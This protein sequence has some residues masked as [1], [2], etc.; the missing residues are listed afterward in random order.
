MKQIE[1]EISACCEVLA[2]GGTILY[3]TDTIWGIGCDATNYN[4]VNK[5][6]ILKQ[7]VESKSLIILL[8]DEKHLSRYV[9]RVPDITHD[10]LSQAGS[11]LTIIYPGA[12]NLAS[13][14]IAGDGTI[15]IRIAGTEFTR[16]LIAAFGKP[17]VSTSAN[18]SGAPSP[19]LFR[20]IDPEIRSG[21]DH[22]TDES[23][24]RLTTTKPSR[25]IRLNL[26]GDFE[27]IR[28]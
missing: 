27:V 6:Y 1:K 14:V 22:V 21:V 4:A 17:I 25:I 18:R 28:E 15:A 3:P 20:S 9:S 8:D 26:N 23:I 5:V 7:R 12:R 13:N 19:A 16:K 24:A 11:P 2:Q 10:L